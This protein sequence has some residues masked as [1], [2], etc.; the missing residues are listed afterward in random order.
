MSTGFHTLLSACFSL[1]SRCLA[2]GI[3]APCGSVHRVTVPVTWP[4]DF[5]HWV[6]C[7]GPCCRLQLEGPCT[8][9]PISS[10]LSLLY[11]CQ[12]SLIHLCLH[13]HCKGFSNFSDVPPRYPGMLKA[14]R[15]VQTNPPRYPPQ[16]SSSV[17]GTQ[18]VRCSFLLSGQYLISPAWENMCYILS[19]SCLLYSFCA[20]SFI[21][22][23]C[24]KAA[25][26]VLNDQLAERIM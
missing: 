17:L 13:C 15:R 6:D 23:M 12:I 18:T 1:L 24:N 3:L 21:M 14:Q 22:R 20:I 5:I 2:L 9:C 10:N 4:L 8:P 7:Y 16:S 25:L 26:N 19:Y 11:V